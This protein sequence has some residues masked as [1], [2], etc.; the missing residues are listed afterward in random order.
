MI[1][2]PASHHNHQ[3]ESPLFKGSQGILNIGHPPQTWRVT[4]I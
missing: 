1:R 2:I 3:I 4:Q